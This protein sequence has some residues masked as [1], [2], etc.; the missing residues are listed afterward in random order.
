MLVFRRFAISRAVQISIEQFWTDFLKNKSTDVYLQKYVYFYFFQK[1]SSPFLS[2]D[3]YCSDDG[4]PRKYQ[5]MIIFN[6][7]KHIYYLPTIIGYE[8]ARNETS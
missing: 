7:I 8:Y 4:K 3:L 5:H 1:I 6:K 2:W